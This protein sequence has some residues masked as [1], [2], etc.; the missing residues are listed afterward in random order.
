VVES[1]PQSDPV[2]RLPGRPLWR[3]KSLLV[4]VT[5]MILGLVLWGRD[6]FN[7]GTVRDDRSPVSSSLAESSQQSPSD[8]R[9]S[10]LFRLGFSY[11][12]GFLIGWLFRKSLKLAL[13][14]A[15]AVGLAIAAS[16][17]SGLFNL[18]W[19]A[20]E[21]H[22]AHS[23]AWLK[24]ELGA[25]KDFLTGYLPSAVVGFVGMFKGARHH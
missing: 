5:A 8:V 20:M 11:A 4:A 17:Y 3:S 12:G 24:G 1:R 18:D 13:L 6:S 9:S 10:A 7:R 21:T 23:L 19:T 15:G 16:K 14:G 22:T 2:S 25:F